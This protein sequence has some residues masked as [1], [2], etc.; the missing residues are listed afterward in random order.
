MG[1][2]WIS[3]HIF[4]YSNVNPMLL[5]CIGPLIEELRERELIRRYFFIRYWQEGHHLRLR[6][7][8]TEGVEQEEI[9]RVVEPVLTDYL[10]RYPALY[11]PDYKSLAKYHKEL[12]LAEYGTDKWLETYSEDGEMP[13]RANNSFHYIQY[14]P[15][16]TR[17]GGVE[18]I[19]VA[20]WHFEQSSDLVI[21]LLREVNLRVR[22]ILLG[23]SVQLWLPLCYAFLED[24]ATMIVFL[25]RY[26]GFWQGRYQDKRD[27]KTFD[28]QYQRVAPD[29]QQR[30]AE[31][32]SYA[33]TGAAGNLTVSERV[34]I[35]HIHE[36]RRRIDILDSERKLLLITRSESGEEQVITDRAT[37]YSRLLS[38]YI[39]MTN[40]RLGAA[41]ADE[42][43]LAHLLKNALEDQILQRQEVLL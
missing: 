36:L 5:D 17:Y 37:V 16:Y 33:T 23:M 14:E 34:W 3:I 2:N 35:E 1:K 24:D 21:R 11:E 13:V 43:Y 12:F 41:I 22:T 40:N 10:K 18:G 4:Y 38:S 6:L 39:H 25:K 29:L 19:E 7:L 28:R 9:K 30:I 32:K 20:E 27:G 31:I 26:I 42:V 8:P 15:E